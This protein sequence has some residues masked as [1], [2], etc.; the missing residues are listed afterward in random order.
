[1]SEEVV[2]YEANVPSLSP[3]QVLSQMT[4]IQELMRT[5]MQVDEHFGTIPGTKKPSLYKAGAEKLGLMF[6]LSPE[7]QVTQTDMGGEH[8][9]Y[10]VHCKLINI[11]SGQVWGSGVGSC[12]TKEAKYRYRTG[13]VEFTGKPVPKDYWKERNQELLGG[14]GF[15]TKK[16]PDTGQWEIVRQGPKVEHDNPADYYNT[17]LKMAKK[18]AHVDAMLTATAASDIFTQDVEDLKAN[19]A[20]YADVEVVE[21]KPKKKPAKKE[22]EPPEEELEFGDEYISKEDRMYLYDLSGKKESIIKDALAE[23]KIKTTHEIHKGKEFADLCQRV[24]QLVAA[25]Q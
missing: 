12:N 6:R 5:A 7:F 14:K 18:R 17:V 23:M 21:E 25:K 20:V 9:E 1:M 11:N 4:V 24:K 22:P 2:R 13:E 16:N 10:V 3:Q 19:E 8:R 15:Q